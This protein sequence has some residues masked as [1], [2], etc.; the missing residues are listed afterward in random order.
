MYVCVYVCMHVCVRMCI[1][2]R[3]KMRCGKWEYER[4]DEVTENESTDR[5][6]IYV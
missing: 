5:L 4:K 1:C 3:D 2:E 6:S